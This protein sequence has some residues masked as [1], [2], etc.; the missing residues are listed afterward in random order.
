MSL[1]APRPCVPVSWVPL[2]SCHSL[3]LTC[4]QSH[5]LL[6]TL[7]RI[8]KFTQRALFT[9]PP[10]QLPSLLPTAL[11]TA[12]SMRVAS[13]LQDQLLSLAFFFLLIQNAVRSWGTLTLCSCLEAAVAQSV[14]R[15]WS[16][17]W[18]PVPTCVWQF[19]S[20]STPDLFLQSRLLLH[21]AGSLR[22]CLAECRPERQQHHSLSAPATPHSPELRPALGCES[23][24]TVSSAGELTLPGPP[25][26][27][28]PRTASLFPTGW[29]V[30]QALAGAP[31]W[32]EAGDVFSR[33]SL[34]SGQR[35][36]FS[37]CNQPSVFFL[38]VCAPVACP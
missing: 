33:S 4:A 30:P 31:L 8:H 37:E 15:T 20:C 1:S 7:T 3:T 32:A 38:T 21:G 35:K 6:H 5:T 2:S 23:F 29:C 10:L 27:S 24:P 18:C 34:P 14:P 12:E 22:T 28:T 17:I 13:L 26:I 11:P 19:G 25:N 9:S 36:P 16:W